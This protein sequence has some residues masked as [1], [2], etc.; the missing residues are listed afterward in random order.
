P[1]LPPPTT[2]VTKILSPQTTGEDQP[3]PGMAVLQ[4]TLRLPLQVSGRPASSVVPSAWAPRNCGQLLSAADG[5]TR[6]NA[7][8]QASINVRRIQDSPSPPT[9]LPGVPGRG[10]FGAQTM[11]ATCASPVSEGT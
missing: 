1:S 4:T 6:H 7:A 3:R 8:R 2:L 5:P 9:P 10:E 11:S